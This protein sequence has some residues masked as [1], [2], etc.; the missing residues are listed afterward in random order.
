MHEEVAGFTPEVCSFPKTYSQ[1]WHISHQKVPISHYFQV[2]FPNF[3]CFAQKKSAF[4]IQKDLKFAT[5]LWPLKVAPFSTP[6]QAH[7][8]LQNLSLKIWALGSKITKSWWLFWKFG[9][10]FV[11]KKIDFPSKL[12]PLPW[13]FHISETNN[14]LLT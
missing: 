6:K 7:F 13:F 14:P 12:L 5:K 9:G 1:N 2:I 10:K 4:F 8:L 11:R 3:P